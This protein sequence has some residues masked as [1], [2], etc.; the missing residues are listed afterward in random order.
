MKRLFPYLRLLKPVR[1]EFTAAVFYGLIFGAT[2]GL[3]L[4]VLLQKVFPVVFAEGRQTLTTIELLSFASILPSVFLLRGIAGFRNSYLISLCGVNVLEQIRMQFFEKIQRL[5]LSFFAKNQSGDLLARGLG[6]ANQLQNT[7][8]TVAN[9][10]IKQPATLISAVGALIYLSI[11]YNDVVFI[12][13]CL[14]LVPLSVFPIRMVGKNLLKRARQM[15]DQSGGVTSIFSENLTATKEIRAFGLEGREMT[16]FRAALNRLMVLQ[17]KVVKY[18]N[19]LS[20]TIEFISTIGVSLSLIYAYH[21]RLPWEVF[22]ALVG[23]LYMCYDPIKKIGALNNETKRGLSALDRLEEVLHAPLEITD[24]PQPTRVDRLRGEIG[25]RDVSFS[26]KTGEPVLRGVNITIPAGTV[27]ALVGPSGAGKSTFANLVPRFYEVT[28]G[29][30]TIDG[31]DLR[32]MR[33]SDLR[34]NIAL[35]SQEPVLFNDTIFNNLLLG[36]PDA[37]REEVEQAA[38]DAFAHDFIVSQP[39]GY[40]TFVGER[41]GKLSGGQKQR[42]ALARAFLRNAPILILDEATSALDSESEAFIQ[43]A[44]RKL[45]VGKT[46]LIIAHRFSTI[47]DASMILVFE[48]GRIVATG[49]HTSVYDSSV[50]YRSLYDKQHNGAHRV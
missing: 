8:T 30:V 18:S 1:V 12:L 43:L 36:R 16:R 6:D 4:P 31:I 26:Y 39:Q 27:C 9:E 24:P 45:V 22:L 32:A 21:A 15:Q 49:T 23:A 29:G 50:V 47:R 11:Q 41:G 40:D 14:A 25:F 7:I 38:K 3:G 48:N 13:L 10:S 46:V 44:L 2:S 33:L 20:P 19:I 35:V 34:R 42:I 37:T 17:L 28:D 5:P